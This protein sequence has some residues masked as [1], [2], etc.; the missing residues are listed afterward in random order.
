MLGTALKGGEGSEN[1]LRFG[2]VERLSFAKKQ[3]S[4]FGFQPPLAFNPAVRSRAA[5][6]A[7]ELVVQA[8]RSTAL[9][10]QSVVQEH[11]S[12][13]RNSQFR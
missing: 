11:E 9:F 1:I 4:L 3:V 8:R 10:G 2:C 6:A 12:P 13:Q 7:S 5:F